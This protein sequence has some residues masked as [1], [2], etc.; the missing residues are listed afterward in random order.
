MKVLRKQLFRISDPCKKT[1][2]VY[3]K[4]ANCMRVAGL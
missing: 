2:S 1:G 4:N 3:F